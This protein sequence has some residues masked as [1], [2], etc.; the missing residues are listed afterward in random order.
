MLAGARWELMWAGLAAGAAFF[1][2]LGSGVQVPFPDFFFN[3]LCA[4]AA[5]L[6]ALGALGMQAFLKARSAPYGWPSGISFA[7]GACW[8][9][10]IAGSAWAVSAGPGGLPIAFFLIFPA[11]GLGMGLQVVAMLLFMRTERSL[12]A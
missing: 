7:S 5:G 8:L 6:Q 4:L 1:V 12:S 3:G 2:L 11:A 10:V 9:L